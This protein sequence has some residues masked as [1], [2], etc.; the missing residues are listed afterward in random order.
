MSAVPTPAPQSEGNPAVPEMDFVHLC[1]GGPGCAAPLPQGEPLAG[2]PLSAAGK[3]PVLERFW[4]LCLPDLQHQNQCPACPQ[5]PSLQTLLLVLLFLQRRA[6][7]L[8]T[9]PLP[10]LHL[11]QNKLNPLLRD[12]LSPL[13]LSVCCPRPHMCSVFLS[14]CKTCQWEER[15][16]NF[17]LL[18]SA[19]CLGTAHLQ[20]CALTVLWELSTQLD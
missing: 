3:E 8:P 19:W 15:L 5:Q 10:H 16:H 18:G 14:C 17:G 9:P 12:F 13:L 6:F 1:S 4:Q 2:R 20:L 11:T 7:P